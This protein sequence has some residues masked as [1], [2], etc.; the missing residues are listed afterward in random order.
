MERH[1]KKIRFFIYIFAFI[2]LVGAIYYV[3]YSISNST[4]K[5]AQCRELFDS[6]DLENKK[7][8]CCDSS[9][10]NSND[11]LC[12]AKCD[13]IGVNPDSSYCT[14][15]A[16]KQDQPSK[17]L[18]TTRPP[19]PSK[20]L[21]ECQAI[22]IDPNVQKS[23]DQFVL[24]AGTPLRLDYQ[25]YSPGI[26]ARSYIYEFFSYDNGQNNYQ[27]VTFDSGKSYIG[28]YNA[29]DTG[30]TN[31]T[32]EVVALHEDLYKPDLNR[33]GKYPENILMTL[34]IIDSQKNR[35]LQGWNCFV[36]IKLDQTP[37][38]CK[39][40]TV[41]DKE[42]SKGETV[43]ITVTPNTTK[44]N[45][46]DFRI[47]NTENSNEEVSL[48]N[49]VNNDATGINNSRILVKGNN[50]KP[51]TLNLTWKDLYVKDR[52]T[53]EYL[54]NLKIKSFV[55]PLEN[56]TSD[57]VA[58]CSVDLKIKEDEGVDN[59]EEVNITLWRQSENQTIRGVAK[60]A[61]GKYTMKSTDFITIYS[62]AKEKDIKEFIYSFHNLDNLI[63]KDYGK[64]KGYT[65]EGIRNAYNINF[66]KD[67][68]LIIT[69]FSSANDRDKSIDIF[70]E[71]INSIDLLTGRR[72]KNVQIRGYFKNSNN[73]ISN[74]D[75]DCVKDFRIE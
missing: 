22:G 53:G 20:Q 47:L 5:L 3:S 16:I 41:S 72:P 54:K 28:Y 35:R 10:Y 33:D 29:S 56:V 17:R 31:Q 26:K 2:A 34:S 4:A 70:Y 45:N 40:I 1:H 52:N 57:D 68:D 58:S 60:D 62:K 14:E 36:K 66:K 46:Y 24:K 19:E 30:K 55:R 74:I 75:S 43:K 42:I 6:K 7:K 44:V 11:S 48:E 64:G 13:A 61:D 69:K 37:N 27:A 73:E 21:P 18:E 12:A 63:D 51:I 8:I 49:K 71:D 23:G 39:S 67:V 32:N 25:I 65:K 59:C 9:H 38:Y 50:D 15:T